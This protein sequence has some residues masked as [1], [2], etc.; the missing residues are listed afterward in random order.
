MLT[1]IIVITIGLPRVLQVITLRTSWMISIESEITPS[2]SS[3][4]LHSLSLLGLRGISNIWSNSISV[5]VWLMLFFNQA[6]AFTVHSGREE[7]DWSAADLQDSL[8]IPSA[9]GH[10]TGNRAGLDNVAVRVGH[11]DLI[12]VVGHSNKSA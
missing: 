9:G 8:S 4:L 11:E 1:L 7:F 10:N 6:R 12:A 5:S 3:E 2:D